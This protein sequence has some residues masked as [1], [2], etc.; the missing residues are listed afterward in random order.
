MLL[1]ANAVIAPPLPLPAWFS[2]NSPPARVIVAL[3]SGFEFPVD[4]VADS[5][6]FHCTTTLPPS[7]FGFVGE[8]FVSV[9]TPGLVGFVVGAFTKSKPL[10]VTGP[11]SVML[12][13]GPA[14]SLT[15][16]E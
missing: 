12:Q 13:V 2:H 6:E 1:V 8:V 10:P 16:V 4:V 11:D 7:V 14:K 9:S 5:A 15:F 3:P